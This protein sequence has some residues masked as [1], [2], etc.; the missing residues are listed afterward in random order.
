MTWMYKSFY[1]IAD[2]IRKNPAQ[3]QW[4]T[5]FAAEYTPSL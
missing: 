2:I 5:G 1:A 3:E 4:N